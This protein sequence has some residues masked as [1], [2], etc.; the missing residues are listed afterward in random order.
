MSLRGFV[1]LMLPVLFVIAACDPCGGTLSCGQAPRVAVTGLVLDEG[2]GTPVAGARIQ[3][4][5][6]AGVQLVAEAGET[7]TTANG[8]FV[9]ELPAAAVGQSVVRL[10]VASPGADAYEIR[11]LAVRATTVAGEAT[12]L[13]PLRSA[14]PLIPSIVVLFWNGTDDEPVDSAEV[15]FR[16]TG[17]ARLFSQGIEVQRAT[18]TTNEVG[19]LLLFDG[20]TTDAA[21]QVVGDLVVRFGSPLDSTVFT[22]ARFAAVAWFVASK[23]FVRVGVGP[24]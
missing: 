21:D 6:E 1:I 8:T 23:G 5:R 17:G 11:G 24:N 13:K 4:W 7:S 3:L 15:E 20:L 19:W 9:V 14:H 22:N 16:R 18:G 12:I 10:V 2:T